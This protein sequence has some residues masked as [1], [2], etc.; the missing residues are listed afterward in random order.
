MS[1]KDILLLSP[2]GEEEVLEL[3]SELLGDTLTRVVEPCEMGEEFLARLHTRDADWVVLVDPGAFLVAPNRLIELL[4]FMEQEGF[5]CSG[6]PDGGVLK[7]RSGNPLVAHPFFIALHAKKLRQVFKK[8]AISDDTLKPNPA[9]LLPRHLIRYPY[10]LR[11][12]GSSDSFFFALHNRALPI[13]WL[14]AVQ[15]VRDPGSTILADHQRRPFLIHTWAT[16]SFKQQK[17]RFEQAKKF[18]LLVQEQMQQ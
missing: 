17:P 12:K 8:K 5:V 14:D 15:W 4:R 3:T 6:M 10:S 2:G 16:E 13:L 9:E 18:S 1:S 7:L 11:A